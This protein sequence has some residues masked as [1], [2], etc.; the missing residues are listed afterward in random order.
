LCLRG[1]GLTFIALPHVVNQSSSSRHGAGWFGTARN[2]GIEIPARLAPG[3]V[4]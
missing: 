3:K 1:L 4:D 2:P